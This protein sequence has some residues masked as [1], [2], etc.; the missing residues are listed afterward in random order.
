[1]GNVTAEAVGAGYDGDDFYCDVAIPNAALLRV[2]YEDDWTLAFHHTRPYWQNHVVVVPKRHVRSLTTLG[3]GDADLVR[4]LLIVIADVARSF[5]QRDAAAS[6]IT[7]LGAYQDSHHLHVHVHS[8]GRRQG[9]ASSC[10]PS[11]AIPL[12]VSVRRRRTEE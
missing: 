6:V 11:D 5:E 12:A 10:P 3:D 2:E 1:M 9:E 7:N 8:G 4:R